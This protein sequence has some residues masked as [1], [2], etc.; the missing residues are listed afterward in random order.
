MG[1]QEATDYLRGILSWESSVLARIALSYVAE[2]VV[3]REGVYE[4]HAVDGSV[5]FLRFDWEACGNNSVRRVAH[6]TLTK[7]EMD[8]IEVDH[9]WWKAGGP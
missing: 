3:L 5:A 4:F 7:E 2:Y 6:V 1:T 9:A 8:A